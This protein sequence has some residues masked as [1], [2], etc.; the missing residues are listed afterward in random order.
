MAYRVVWTKVAQSDLRSLVMYIAAD[1]PQAAKKFGYSIVQKAE[2]AGI[3]PKSGRIVPEKQDESIREFILQPYRIVYEISEPDEIIYIFRIWHA[4][5][6]YL[7][8]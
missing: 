6:G 4:A 2:D 3:F 1:N 8:A 7:K 5:R